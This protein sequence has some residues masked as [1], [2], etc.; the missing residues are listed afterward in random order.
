[1]DFSFVVRVWSWVFT[2][3]NRV[4]S[5]SRLRPR[6]ESGVLCSETSCLKGWSYGSVPSGVVKPH[7]PVL[8]RS[9]S[10]TTVWRANGKVNGYTVWSH[11][12]YT[13]ICATPHDKTLR[14]GNSVIRS[15]TGSPLTTF[16]FTVLR[17]VFDDVYNTRSGNLSLLNNF[18]VFGVEPSGRTN[19]YTN[20]RTLIKEK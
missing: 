4:R 14:Y 6:T 20:L 11:K 17:I 5:R 7:R 12:K 10:F 15:I 18:S 19:I 8:T 1:M 2:S 3:P 16:K 9:S 13:G